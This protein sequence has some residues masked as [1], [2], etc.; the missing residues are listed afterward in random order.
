MTRVE[1]M[2][3]HDLALVLDWA[4]AEGWNPGLDDA[5]VFF[6]ADPGGFLVKRVEG[7]VVSAI[8]VVNH[9]PELAFLG[10]YITH[11]GFRG[12]GHGRDVWAAGLAHAGARTVG[13][14]G[15]PA[16][17]DTYALAGF[18]RTGRTVRFA[19]RMQAA[20]G[21]A[22]R[23][24]TEADMPALLT[25]D[26]RAEGY[27]RDAFI[28]PWLAGCA[29]RRTRVI[30]GAAGSAPAYATARQCRE[31]QKIGP[32]AC[33]TEAEARALIGA[34]SAGGPVMIDVPDTSPDLA[35]L[36]EREGF[37]PVFETARMYLGEPP[38]ASPPRFAAVASLELG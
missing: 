6:G 27:S 14:D 19:G 11:P 8:S 37:S 36:L 24:A 28:R 26:A 34:L 3:Q 16:Q 2:T 20:P 23:P 21:P 12:Q 22:P 10:L 29:T 35:A 7:R 9:A 5:S 32:L 17:L 13:L 30:D 38:H 1:P 31:G 18:E 25:S 15:V 4:A 33:G